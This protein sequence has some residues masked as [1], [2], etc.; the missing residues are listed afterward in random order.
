MSVSFSKTVIFLI[1]F[2][3]MIPIL[4]SSVFSNTFHKPEKIFNNIDT[5]KNI[6]S[7]YSWPTPGYT[8]IS[9][10]F[11]RRSSPTKFASS[12]HKG[13][14]IAAPAGSIVVAIIDSKVT[15]TGFSGSGGYTIVLEDT[16]LQF[17]YHHMSPSFLVSPGMYVY[18]GDVIG[19]VGPKNIYGVTNN[20]YK[21]SNR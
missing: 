10:Y 2:M 9:S 3:I 14:D 11:G 13:I 7:R 18:S 4:F 21:D 5:S 8:R 17:V 19:H 15:Y 12:F 6:L 20:P 16:H 1:V